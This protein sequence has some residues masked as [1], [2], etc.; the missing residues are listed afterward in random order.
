[1][2]DSTDK[3]IRERPFD[4]FFCYIW[5][6]KGNNCNTYIFTDI[7]P[8]DRPHIIV[9]PGITISDYGERC[10]ESLE[11]HIKKDGFKIEDIGLIINTHC[12][13]DHCQANEL[14]VQKSNAD[15]TLSEKEENF[16]QTTGR[17]LD[18]MFGTKSP[19]FT[20]RFY[21]KEGVLNPG[22]NNKLKLRVIITPGHSPGSVCLYWPE[23]KALISGD[24][25]YCGCVSRT[26]FPGRSRAELEKSIDRLSQL[27]VEYLF[28]GPKTEFGCIINGKANV[29]RNFQSIKMSF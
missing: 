2:F 22:N 25:V 14:I 23:H 6:G 4:N 13:A 10:F 9:D 21:L 19:E 1:M 26:D 7:L 12:H 24:V 20:P 17:K 27:D 8:G 5:Q 29:E 18:A 3:Y 28:P 11:E 16:R 15:I